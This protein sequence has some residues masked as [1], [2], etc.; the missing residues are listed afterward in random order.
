[1]EPIFL[2]SLIFI[3]LVIVAIWYDKIMAQSKIGKDSPL[4][5]FFHSNKWEIKPMQLLF[6][7]FS[8]FMAYFTFLEGPHFVK[9]SPGFHSSR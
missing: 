1:M 4:S 6:G 9:H 7:L 3:C 5:V 8:L 2:F